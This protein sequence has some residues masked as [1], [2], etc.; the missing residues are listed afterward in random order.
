[1]RTK[2]KTKNIVYLVFALTFFAIWGMAWFQAQQDNIKY[3]CDTYFAESGTTYTEV[4]ETIQFDSYEVSE[5]YLTNGYPNYENVT[6]LN[7]CAPM[8]GTLLLGY[9]DSTYTDII[10]DF[11]SSYTY[12]GNFY[13]RGTTNKVIQVKEYL[14]ELMGTNTINP[15]TSV[16]QFKTGLT[17]YVNE[18]GYSITYTSCGNTF[19]ISNAL[20]HIQNQKP[21]ALF[22]SSYTYI[23]FGC[24]SIH[25]DYMTIIQNVSSNGHAMVCFGYREYNYYQNDEV[26][27]TDKYLIVAFGD[28]TQGLLNINSLSA[29]DEAYAVNIF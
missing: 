26:F 9:Y 3:Y 18:K 19:S 2:E 17:S 14:Y 1:M 25:D 29:V 11:Q 21:I 27:R 28:G 6:Q 22:V 4:E 12:N 20:T 8:A 16:S 13:Y 5:T 23:P 10:E 24:Y 15:G 7:S